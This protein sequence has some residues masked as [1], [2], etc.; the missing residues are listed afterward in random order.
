M[1]RRPL[2]GLR[3]AAA[4]R[5]LRLGPAAGAAGR[6]GPLLGFSCRRFLSRPAAQR[7]SS[8]VPRGRT[9]LGGGQAASARP[10]RVGPAGRGA[11]EAARGEQPAVRASS[12]RLYAAGR[13]A[14]RSAEGGRQPVSSGSAGTAEVPAAHRQPVAGP[15]AWWRRAEGWVLAKRIFPVL[16]SRRTRRD[17][18]SRRWWMRSADLGWEGCG[19]SCFQTA[20]R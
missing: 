3:V 13:E 4:R 5:G 20:G 7:C 11:G 9:V 14:A 17:R 8:P 15:G 6:A 2:P 18:R 1:L 19:G 12:R 10:M 16:P